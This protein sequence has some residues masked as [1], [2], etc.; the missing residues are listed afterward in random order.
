MPIYEY[1]CTACGG[2]VEALIRSGTAAPVCPDCGS[3][4]T[5]RLFSPSYLLSSESRRPA[6]HTC[7][8]REERCD[9]PPCSGSGTCRRD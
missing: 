1:R 3:P 9:T 7:C 4:L 5:D 6:G 8:G 2:R